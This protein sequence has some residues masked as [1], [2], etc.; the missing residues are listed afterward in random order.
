MFEFKD[1]VATNDKR[2]GQ[3]RF[4][5]TGKVW[6]PTPA[7]VPLLKKPHMRHKGGWELLHLE[8]QNKEGMPLQVVTEQTVTFEQDTCSP[9]DKLEIAHAEGSFFVAITCTE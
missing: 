3:N 6:V 7:Y 5:V 8:V 2:D 9:Y 4:T 1:F